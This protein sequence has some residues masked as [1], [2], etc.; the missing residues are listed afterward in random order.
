V[1]FE[2]SEEEGLI[3]TQGGNIKCMNIDGIAIHCLDLYVKGIIAI[4]DTIL[5]EKDIK[6]LLE[7]DGARFEYIYEK[8]DDL[9]ERIIALEESL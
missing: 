3:I 9:E 7:A 6:E 4:G 8:L 1:N 2:I 5:Y